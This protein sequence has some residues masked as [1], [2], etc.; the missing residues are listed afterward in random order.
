ML[1]LL[2]GWRSFVRHRRR[3]IIT[4]LAV[5]FS[6]AMM[7]TFVGLSTDSHARMAEMGVRLGSGH[8]VIQPVGYQEDP[9]LD[10]LLSDPA[11]VVAE[12][13]KLDGVVE[14]TARLN[15]SGLIQ[16]GELSSA[17]LLSGVMPL[18]EPTLSSIAAPES[19]VEGDY[20][21]RREDME[22]KKNPADI[23][24]GVG[25]A[26]HLE[27]AIGDRV[28]LT[29]SPRVGSEPSSAAFLVRGTFRTGVGEIDK[30]FA[31]IP[32]SE[33][34]ALLD[35]GT[36]VTQVAVLLDDLEETDAATRALAASVGSDGALEVISW[37][38]ALRELY[39]ALV[40]DDQ[41]MYLMMAIIFII[42]AIG[43]FNTVLMS[44]AE[45]TREMGV[46][47]AIGTSKTRL[48][49]IVMAEATVLA[50]VSAA[51]GVG[52]GLLGHY[53]L[54]TEG[55]DIA[56]MAGGEY[57]FAGIA[58]SGKVYSRLTTEVVVRWALV[59]I[60]LVLGSTVYPALRATRLR[61]VEAM[62]HV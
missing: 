38:V 62:R 31:Q 22:F 37:K 53:Y 16:A 6:L 25:L 17:V 41:S 50:L 57:E 32:I 27:V 5:A 59:V 18:T 2:L 12:A 44:V 55:L 42:V 3:S 56:A 23:Y 58:F 61:P 14:A 1:S 54:S 11:A 24:L 20:L 29:V 33:A 43:I 30:T 34:Q 52:L 9:S 48:F 26:S 35:A 49:S 13:K 8:V 46:M 19:R 21:R 39:E 36:G 7:I 40:L 28:V 10:V 60:G 47:M 51:L 45:R 15:S 4:T